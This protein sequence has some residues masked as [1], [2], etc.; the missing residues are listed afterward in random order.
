[1]PAAH[2]V[3]APLCPD[4]HGSC[5]IN[6]GRH[7]GTIKRNDQKEDINGEEVERSKIQPQRE[8]GRE[9]RDAQA[10]AGSPQE[11]QGWKREES[12]AGDRDRSVGGAEKGQEGSTQAQKPLST[13]GS[14]ISVGA[15]GFGG[16]GPARR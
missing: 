2:S 16:A 12:E 7:D 4:G 1:M 10:E 15:R 14:G 11:R 8:Q 6:Y 3:L 5:S 13:N 9:A